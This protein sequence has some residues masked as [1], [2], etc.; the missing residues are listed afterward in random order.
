MTKM[1]ENSQREFI[2]AT[3]YLTKL[4]AFCEE[5]TGSAD[6]GRAMHVS[7]PDWSQALD[8]VPC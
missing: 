2:K 8:P 3:S 6:E 5:M 1:V 4:V 7:Y